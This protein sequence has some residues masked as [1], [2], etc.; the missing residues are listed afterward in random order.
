MYSCFIKY[1]G[2]AATIKHRV[3]RLRNILFQ[4]L[5]REDLTSQA[6]IRN[7]QCLLAGIGYLPTCKSTSLPH[8]DNLSGVWTPGRLSKPW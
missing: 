4:Q 6:D 2:R 3:C 8:Y 7:P 1:R 5:I